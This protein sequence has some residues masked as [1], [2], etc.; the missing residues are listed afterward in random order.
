MFDQSSPN[1]ILLFREVSKLLVA[2]GSRI[3]SLPVQKDVYR[4][5]YKGVWVSL[6]ILTRGSYTRTFHYF[7]TIS[8]SHLV[9]FAGSDYLTLVIPKRFFGLTLDRL[10]PYVIHMIE[11]RLCFCILK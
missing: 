6:V 10:A 3:L 7:N 9:G 1:G 2:Y 4:M 5:K 8:V 11:H